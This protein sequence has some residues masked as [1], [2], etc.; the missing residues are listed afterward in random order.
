MSID[1][2]MRGEKTYQFWRTKGSTRSIGQ[3][4]R[5]LLADHLCGS[6]SLVRASRR[7]RRLSCGASV[8]A[9]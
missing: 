9:T 1:R 8:R 6:H 7:A 4:A 5:A 2:Q 3:L